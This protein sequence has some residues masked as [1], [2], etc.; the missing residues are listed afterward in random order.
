[1]LICTIEFSAQ[2]LKLKY[3]LLFEVIVEEKA[4]VVDI[5]PKEAKV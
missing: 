5:P 3:I 4:P 2:N 1:M